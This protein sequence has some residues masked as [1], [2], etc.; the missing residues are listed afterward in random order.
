M[1]SYVYW[2]CHFWIF[3]IKDSKFYN[4]S[5]HIINV[6]ISYLEKRT[7]ST[8]VKSDIV[9]KQNQIEIKFD[10]I[11]SHQLDESNF[12][13][14]KNTEGCWHTILCT[15]ICI[16][17]FTWLNC[18]VR[19]SFLYLWN[20]ASFPFVVYEFLDYLLIYLLFNIEIN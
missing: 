14:L 1:K 20:N 12:I 17:N 10:L 2:L 15:N 5:C 4:T 7:A 3:W 6:G 13:S 19:F 9:P 18:N 11:Q 8:K 16:Q